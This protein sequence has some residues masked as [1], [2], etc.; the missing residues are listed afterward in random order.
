MNKAWIVTVVAALVLGSAAQAQAPT[1]TKAQTKVWEYVQQSWVDDAA[2]NGKWPGDYT[3]DNAISW[4]SDWP[5]S[6]NKATWEKWTRFRDKGS[7]TIAYEISPN[8][9]AIA[10]DTAVVHYTAVTVTE[11]ADGDYERNVMGIVE[12]LILDDGEWL[13]LSSVNLELDLDD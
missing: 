10:G 3:H 11:G 9:I 4:G 7:Q 6:Q 13:Y 2:E 8:A 5:F 12:T 1:W